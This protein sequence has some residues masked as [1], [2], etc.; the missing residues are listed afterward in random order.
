MDYDCPPILENTIFDKTLFEQMEVDAHRCISEF[1]YTITIHGRKFDD[2]PSLDWLAAAVKE[3]MDREN[4]QS[5]ELVKVVR[6]ID[7][8]QFKYDGGSYGI[9]VLTRKTVRNDGYCHFG[10]KKEADNG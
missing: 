4:G 2:V 5:E 1:P 8:E 6:C 10:R 3:K 9:C 7:C